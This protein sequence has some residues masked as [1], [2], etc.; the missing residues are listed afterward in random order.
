MLPCRLVLGRIC[1]YGAGTKQGTRHQEGLVVGLE[2]V[3][4]KVGP[5]GCK[6]LFLNPR[7]MMILLLGR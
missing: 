3:G 4:L 5:L 7:M 2:C 6:N 1:G